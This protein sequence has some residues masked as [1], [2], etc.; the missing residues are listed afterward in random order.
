MVNTYVR[1]ETKNRRLANGEICFLSHYEMRE[2]KT[3]L[4][5]PVM[6]VASGTVLHM[7]T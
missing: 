4:F 1:K 5:L 7:L 3:K 2:V 6:S